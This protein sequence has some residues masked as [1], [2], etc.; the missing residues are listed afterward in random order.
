MSLVLKKIRVGASIMTTRECCKAFTCLPRSVAH[1]DRRT[2][3][4][5]EAG[6][7]TMRSLS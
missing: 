2:E 3:V 5:C 7:L 6:E 4:D 1:A